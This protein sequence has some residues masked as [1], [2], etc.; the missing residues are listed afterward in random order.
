[1]QPV[2]SHTLLTFRPWRPNSVFKLQQETQRREAV[3]PPRV[4]WLQHGSIDRIFVVRVAQRAQ[5][6]LPP[7]VGGAPR[8]QS[9]RPPPPWKGG[10]QGWL[11]V[12]SLRRVPGR[13]PQPWQAATPPPPPPPRAEIYP[14]SARA[15]GSPQPQT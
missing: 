8:G 2:S 14:R 9:A 3:P 12:N 4:S 15:E 11:G 1:M 5:P 7:G 6:V 13:A 10:S